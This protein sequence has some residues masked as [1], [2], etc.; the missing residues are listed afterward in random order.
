MELA[1]RVLVGLIGLPLLALGLKSMFRPVSMLDDL[2][3]D[4]R[5]AAGLNTVRGVIG[6]LFLAC[7]A[8]IG[9]GLLQSQTLWFVAV[10]LLMGLAALGRVVGIALDGFDRAVVRPIVAELVI[11]AVLVGAHLGLGELG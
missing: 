7:V 9:L 8:M 4:P 11:A 10:A 1:V 2:A 6:G 5:G 3:L